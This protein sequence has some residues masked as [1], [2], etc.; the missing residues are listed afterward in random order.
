ME[1]KCILKSVD[2]GRWDITNE[3]LTGVE[4]VISDKSALWCL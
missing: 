1:R 2:V 3:F 4:K